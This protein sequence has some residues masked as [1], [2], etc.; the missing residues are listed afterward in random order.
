MVE[1]LIIILMNTAS[2]L[3]IILILKCGF[4][5]RLNISTKHI[6]IIAGIHILFN[7]IAISFFSNEMQTL[8]TFLFIVICILVTS[9]ASRIKLC[10]LS[11]PAVLVYIQCFQLFDMLEKL[12]TDNPKMIQTADGPISINSV[13]VDIILFILLFYISYQWD[14]KGIVFSITVGEGI[15]ITIFCILSPT[16]IPI[17][18]FLSEQNSK[19]M[20]SEVW[21]LCW[22]IFVLVLNTAILLGIANRKRSAI[23]KESAL[24][25]QKYFE[26]EYEYL[27]EYRKKQ[28]EINKLRHDW[29][30]HISLVSVM[31]EQK[32]YEKA[33]KYIASLPLQ[34]ESEMFDILTGNEVAD[35]IL[36]V[37]KAEALKENIEFSFQGNMD[38]LYF[39]EPIHMCIILSNALDNGIEACKKVE[40]DSFIRV[41]VTQ[42]K[43]MIMLQIINSTAGKVDIR[44][45]KL[46]TTKENPQLHGFG[47]NNIIEVVNNYK[48][49]Y[50]IEADDKTFYLKII[51]EV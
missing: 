50:M 25:Y 6:G 2:V 48:G 20:S 4:G 10:L 44:E 29:N 16:Y 18:N 14:K 19:E 35:I 17:L 21:P 26:L 1:D 46:H 9:K 12:I 38:K 15:F 41:S 5:A 45:N 37:K 3:N 34:Q 11:I 22:V 24:V 39:I 13:F 51:F 27:C 40:Q 28:E 31:W 7:C 32:E 43:N 36:N 33:A 8:S 23:Y 42:N 30:N 49:R 47:F